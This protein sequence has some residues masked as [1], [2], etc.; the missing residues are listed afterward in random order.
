MAS[1]RKPRHKR[2]EQSKQWRQNMKPYNGNARFIEIGASDAPFRNF[3]NVDHIVT[4]RFEQ[5]L[6]EVDVQITPM[7]KGKEPDII[8]GIKGTKDIPAK[9]EKQVKPIG[10]Q[11]IIA[12]D[13]GQNNSIEFADLQPAMVLYNTLIKQINALLVPN[14]CLAPLAVPK[15]ADEEQ[16]AGSNGNEI[17]AVEESDDL[18]DEPFLTEEELHVLA[19]PVKEDG[20]PLS[21]LDELTDAM[22][23]EEAD[24]DK[25]VN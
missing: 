18:E 12:Y 8:H 15:A 20:S 1:N 7:I 5:A 2:S 16:I 9:T 23:L 25:P 17:S 10:W 19:H 4:I 13:N 24:P 21:D 14:C 11:I 6:R 22:G 3:I